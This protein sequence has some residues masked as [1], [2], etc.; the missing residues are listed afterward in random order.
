V[1]QIAAAAVVCPSVCVAG[2]YQSVP[3]RLEPLPGSHSDGDAPVSVIDVG[4]SGVGG[5]RT[6]TTSMAVTVA[7]TALVACCSCCMLTA[8]ADLVSDPASSDYQPL[9]PDDMQAQQTSVQLQQTDFGQVRVLLVI[10]TVLC[11]RW[12]HSCIA[13]Y[14]YIAYGGVR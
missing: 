7:L 9:S 2:I 3:V 13:Y 1:P 6:G 12:L 8:T 14:Y 5:T 10:S 4:V 11:R